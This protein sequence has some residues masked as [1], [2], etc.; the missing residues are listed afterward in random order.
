MNGKETV[1]NKIT[2]YSMMFMTL[3]SVYQGKG[4]YI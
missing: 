3:K 4:E 1:L 2:F